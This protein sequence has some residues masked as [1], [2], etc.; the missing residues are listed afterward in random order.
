M[1]ESI[2]FQEYSYLNN[3]IAYWLINNNKKFNTRS[4]YGYFG[5]E[6]DYATIIKALKERGTNYGTDALMNEFVECAIAD[7]N[8]HS[9]LPDYVTGS[10]NTK[11]TKDVYVDMNKRVSKYEVENGASP[12]VVYT[13]S[14][15]TLNSYLTRIGCD[16][17]G[18]C[19]SYYCACN[20]LQQ[21]FY[22]LCGIQVKEATIASVAGTTSNGTGHPGINTTVAWFNQKYGKNIKIA[23]KNFSDLGS[24]DTERWNKLVEYTSNGAVFCHI[25]YRNKWGHY[26]VLQS[27]NKDTVTVL[28]SLGNKCNSAYCGYIENRSKSDQL[29]YMRGISQPSIA[30]LYI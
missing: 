21:A 24:N 17:L 22:R 10:D 26:E 8:N 20:S 5:R 28:N 16:G 2:T 29:S 15:T 3:R 13:Q 1:K 19:T 14:S 25:L 9:F 4:I 6:A 18:Q 30:Y 7:N 12:N 11:Y 23:W 27:V